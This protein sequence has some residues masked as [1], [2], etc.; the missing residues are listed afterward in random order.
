[1]GIG[2]RWDRFAE[3]V[4]AWTERALGVVLW[5]SMVSA[6]V[7][8]F[9]FILQSVQDMNRQRLREIPA[10]EPEP[11]RIDFVGPWQG[12]GDVTSLYVW[13]RKPVSILAGGMHYGG[14]VSCAYFAMS[15]P[16]NYIGF[17]FEKWWD[18]K[19]SPAQFVFAER[20]YRGDTPEDRQR[21]RPGRLRFGAWSIDDRFLLGIMPLR[22]AFHATRAGLLLREVL[23]EPVAL[24]KI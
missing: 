6:L 7:L 4:G 10:A 17:G 12:G 23:T 5:L 3:W 19:D 20:N 2:E 18:R 22:A 21:A 16:R 15:P 24:E 9:W 14:R 8:A 1:M 13:R 11:V